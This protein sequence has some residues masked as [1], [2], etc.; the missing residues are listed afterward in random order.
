MHLSSKHKKLDRKK[1]KSVGKN[2]YQK[3][4]KVKNGNPGLNK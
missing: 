3:Q 1:L 4:I 2:T